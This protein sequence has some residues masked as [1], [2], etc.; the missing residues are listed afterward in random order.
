MRLGICKKGFVFLSILFSLI[1]TVAAGP[2]GSGQVSHIPRPEHPRPQ[3]QR[4]SWL[5]LNGEWDF[6]FD[7]PPWTKR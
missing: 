7:Y 4:E 2:Q 3:F 6:A 5:N 1:V